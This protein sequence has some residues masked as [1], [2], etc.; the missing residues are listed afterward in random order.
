MRAII[1]TGGKQ[2]RV[3][4]GQRLRVE[5]LH[6]EPGDQVELD[7]VLFVEDDGKVTVGNPI[8]AGAKVTAHVL[9]QPRGPKL[10][11][12]KFKAKIRYRR[13]TGHRQEQTELRIAD[14]VSG[15]QAPAARRRTRATQEEPESGS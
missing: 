12:F 3:V 14:I 8:I 5:R 9:S 1:E 2:Y 13:K 4:P 11:V 7:R 10:T 6:A 15:G